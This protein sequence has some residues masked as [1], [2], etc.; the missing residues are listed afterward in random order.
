VAGSAADAHDIAFRRPTDADHDAVV[1]R[2]DDWA[3]GRSARQLLPRLWFRH[4]SGTSWV[5]AR[6]DGRVV[7][8]AIGFVSPDDPSTGVLHLVAVDPAMRRR[9][10][11]RELVERFLDDATSSGARRA[12]TTAWPDDRRTL[13]FLE[14]LGFRLRDDDG[15]TRLYGT[16]AV[17]DF[18]APGDDRAELDMTIVP[19]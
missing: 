14:R 11:G 2:I 12:T 10:I 17:A 18:D 3:G 5:A 15:R 8:I 7:G 6:D 9:G 19:A 1:R 16:P 13:A 4:F